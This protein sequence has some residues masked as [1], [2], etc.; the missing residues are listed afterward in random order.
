MN[1]VVTSDTMVLAV[2]GVDGETGEELERLAVTF[3]T[4]VLAVG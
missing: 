1:V 2:D 4:V 3:D